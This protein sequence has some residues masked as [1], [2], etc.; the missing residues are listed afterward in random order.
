MKHC[1][2]RVCKN[3]LSKGVVKVVIYRYSQVNL[4]SEKLKI[5][6]D[7]VELI[8][9]NYV[10]YMQ[11]KLKEGKT[12]KIMNICFITDTANRKNF[13]KETLAYI[14]T[15]VAKLSNVGNI[16]VQRVLSTL[17]EMIIRD[18]RNGE[19]YCIRGLVRI[20]NHDGKISIKK[21]KKYSGS[22]LCVVPIASF[23]K[24]VGVGYAG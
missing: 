11:D 12:I 10:M 16:T 23:K 22:T 2:K 17:E 6:K 20:Q 8:L 3:W 13:D 9:Y 7:V 4:I 14:A 15:E 21:S 1:S 24:K 18:V 19:S 5:N